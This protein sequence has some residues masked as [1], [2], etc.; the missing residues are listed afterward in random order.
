[1]NISLHNVAVHAEDTEL[2]HDLINLELHVHAGVLDL[3]NDVEYVFE[4]ID[5][6]DLSAEVPLVL[7]DLIDNVLEL[8]GGDV[9]EGLA[10]DV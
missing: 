1:M 6:V 9:D 5:A 3:T 2:F 7:V 8:L 10:E 4:L